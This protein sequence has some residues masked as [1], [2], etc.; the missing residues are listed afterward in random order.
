MQRRKCNVASCKKKCNGENATLEVAFFCTFC[1][2]IFGIC[3]FRCIFRFS[4]FA[5]TSL[6]VLLGILTAAYVAY[7][8]QHS[9]Y[10]VLVP[11]D[12]SLRNCLVHC[13][14]PFLLCN[15]KVRH[16]KLDKIV[17]FWGCI[18]LVFFAFSMFDKKIEST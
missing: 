13:M 12:T 17:A 5:T 10:I 4:G 11:E 8:R 15:F 9:N 2:V 3:I 6:V 16:A 18:S 14:F 1:S 7:R